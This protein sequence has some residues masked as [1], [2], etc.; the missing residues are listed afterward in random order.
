MTKPMVRVTKHHD[1][2]HLT[3]DGG[4]LC[5]D[6]LSFAEELT[7]AYTERVR[8]NI[9]ADKAFRTNMEA[10]FLELRQAYW[11]EHEAKQGLL[12]KVPLGVRRPPAATGHFTQ[13]NS[14]AVPG[15]YSTIVTTTDFGDP[16]DH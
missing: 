15:L 9:D 6:A 4:V 1:S 10:R 12:I 16:N 2:H 7:T 5:I 8:P 3:R 11:Q 13:V 14:P